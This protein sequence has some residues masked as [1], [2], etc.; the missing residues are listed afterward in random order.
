M[1]P[2]SWEDAFLCQQRN[3]NSVY[4]R[5]I[6]DMGAPQSSHSDHRVFDGEPLEND[7]DLEL[8]RKMNVLQDIEEQILSKKAAILIKTIK[9]IK[10]KLTPDSK[11]ATLRDRVDTILKERHS[12]NFLSKV[13][14]SEYDV[15]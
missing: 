2:V 9:M 13:S 4:P 8:F 14:I 6:H 11:D 3:L 7:I 15:H 10:K 12:L 1:D 5:D